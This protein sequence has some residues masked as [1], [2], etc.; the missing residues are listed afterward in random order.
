MRIL[1]VR[2][3]SGEL[4]I[5]GDLLPSP[6][7]GAPPLRILAIELSPGTVLEPVY[8][9]DGTP[10]IDLLVGA[11]GKILEEGKGVAQ[12]MP[13]PDPDHARSRLAIFAMPLDKASPWW[14]EKG[15]EDHPKG[16]AIQRLIPYPGSGSGW[17]DMEG[18]YNEILREAREASGEMAPPA[19]E[20][21]GKNLPT[22]A[23]AP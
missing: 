22:P 17:I 12:T 19:P 7:R 23:P 15:R 8:N 4:Y 14:P 13:S 16:R 21:N 6:P 11:N 2:S 10:A 5:V 1:E 20:A 18:T 3:D 9:A